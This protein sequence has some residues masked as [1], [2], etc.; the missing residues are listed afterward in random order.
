MD[1]VSRAS[2]EGSI[3]VRIPKGW[4]GDGKPNTDAEGF[5]EYTWPALR[6][7]DFAVVENHLLKNR[8]SPI[9]AVLP[10]LERL[11]Q[12]KSQAARRLMRSLEK[13]AYV[14]LRKSKAMNKLSV[15]EVQEYIDTPDGALFTM[16]LCIQ[17]KHPTITDAE[18]LRIFQ[19]LGYQEAKRLRDLI[20]GIDKLG[21]ST[22]PNQEAEEVVR[23][24]TRRLTGDGSIVGSPKST[25]G[26]PV[27]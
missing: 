8:V 2:G 10:D 15:D 24:D 6:L 25:D 14:D 1:G 13:Q 7:E 22:G 9:D 20:Q 12:V 19:W 5:D 26:T 3:I 16:K 27:A 18:I 23:A 4:Q 17:R 21:N 11:S